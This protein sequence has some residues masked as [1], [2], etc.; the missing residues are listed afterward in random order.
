MNPAHRAFSA[1]VQQ[2][3]HGDAGA[4]SQME[5]DL[6]PIVRRVIQKGAATSGLDR[7]I[8]DEAHRWQAAA[9]ADQDQL[10]GH[11]AHSLCCCVIAQMRPAASPERPAAETVASFA[12]P[13]RC[14]ST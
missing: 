3:R 7:R 14:G 6:I 1:L 11:V 10:I 12:N 8:L 13:E 4:R 9:H 2:A 5:R